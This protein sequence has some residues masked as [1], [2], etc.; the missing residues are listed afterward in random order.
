LSDLGVEQMTIVM[1]GV[2]AIQAGTPSRALGERLKAMAPNRRKT[3]D[4]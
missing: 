2:L 1:E 3:V 4:A